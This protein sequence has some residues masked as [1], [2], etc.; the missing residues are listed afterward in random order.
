MSLLI[1]IFNYFC[2]FFLNVFI[3]N[4]IWRRGFVECRNVDRDRS[5]GRLN[6]NQN[7]RN[8]ERKKCSLLIVRNENYKN[9]EINYNSKDTWEKRNIKCFINIKNRIY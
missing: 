4:S 7:W 8:N 9:R 1:G 5:F 6:Y 2:D 3:L